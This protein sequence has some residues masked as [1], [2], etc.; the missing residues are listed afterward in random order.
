MVRRNGNVT[1]ALKD[2]QFNL[3]GKPTKKPVVQGNTNVIVAPYF[4]GTILTFF[5]TTQNTYDSIEL[6]C[7][8]G[9]KMGKCFL[10]LSC[11]DNV[12]DRTKREV[13]WFY[14]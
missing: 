1:S 12:C 5:N 11:I 2:M 4:P 14:N 3:I 13:N 9:N 10:D 7:F 6:R 8:L